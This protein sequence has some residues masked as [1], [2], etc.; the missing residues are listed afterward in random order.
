[1]LLDLLLVAAGAALLAFSGSQ[2]VDASAALARRARVTP[3]VVGLTVVAAGTSAPELFVS[4]TAALRGSPEIALA[5]VI[6]SNIANVG[7]ILGC[8][9]LIATLPVTPSAMRVEYPVMLLATLAVPLACRDGRL[10]R[11]E[12][13][14]LLAC[15][16]AFLGLSIRLAR[17]EAT[18][19][20]LGARLESEHEKLLSRPV[21]ALLVA[22]VLAIAGLGLGARLLV[23]GASSIAAALGMSERV[24]GLTLVAVGTSLPE[25]V[26]SGAAAYKGHHGLAIANVVGSNIFNLLL[27]LGSTAS[28][29][30]LRVDP[31]LLRQDMPVMAGF[32][33]LLVPL[34]G[35]GR[36][37]GRRG[38]VILCLAYASYLYLL[39][40]A[41]A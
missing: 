28:I 24:I 30:P 39:S 7:L 17:A 20:E 8:C 9:A 3:A 40:R 34:A 22:I 4:L 13:L 35:L 23:G 37:L 31:A 11:A 32:A 19:A 1:M 12:G 36:R 27:I 38:G 15:M 5:N 41:T 14:F 10:D 33:L 29:A 25:L 21:P 2:L 18:T 6:G 26:A 16:A